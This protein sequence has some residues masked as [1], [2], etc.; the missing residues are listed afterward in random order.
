M[1][2][3]QNQ[4]K[5]LNQLSRILFDRAACFWQ[6]SVLL[7]LIA[8]IIGVIVSLIAFPLYMNSI[9]AILTTVLLIITFCLRYKFKTTY[10]DAETMRRQSVLSEGLNWSIG[11]TQFNEWKSRAGKKVLSKF[12]IQKRAEDYYE[13]QENFGAKRL[14][15]MTCE[16]A[17]WTRNIYKKLRFFFWVILSLCLLIFVI[18]L[19]S[20]PL[21][22]ISIDTQSYII[23]AIY[24]LIPVILSLDFL[25]LAL[26]MNRNIH[27]LYEV[28]KDLELIYKQEVI[29]IEGVMRLVSEY[30]CIVSSGVAVPN[31]FFKRY[32]DEIQAYWDKVS[33]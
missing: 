3:I 13:S 28:E 24:L 22:N 23:Y 18:I 33:G 29:K 17:F 26:L 9:A 19:S 4:G 14:A 32:H 11:K 16:S 5:E 7:E 21:L 15:E 25:E 31:W 20:S 8:G 27:A 1:D 10:D 6:V 12:K 2:E 30:N